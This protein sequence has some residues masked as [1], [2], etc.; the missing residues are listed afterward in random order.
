[1]RRRDENAGSENRGGTGPMRWRFAV[2]SIA[3]LAAGNASA[4]LPHADA[5]PV[6]TATIRGRVTDATTGRPLRRARVN[7][8]PAEFRPNQPLENRA[9]TTDADGKFEFTN[10]VAGRYIVSASRDG[11]GSWAFG[12]TRPPESGRQLEI[13]DKS[14]VERVDIAL[15]AGAVVAGRVIDEFGDPAI[16]ATVSLLRIVTTGGTRRATTFTSVNTNDAGE[17]HLVNP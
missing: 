6:G 16:D 15:P 5:K 14:T 13:D 9:T 1:R 2:A 12:P 8:A 3:L 11:Y 10:L 17:F 7:V 4:Q